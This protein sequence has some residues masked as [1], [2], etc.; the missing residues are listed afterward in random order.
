[1]FGLL[2]DSTNVLPTWQSSRLPF[3]PHG[4]RGASNCNQRF[5]AIFLLQGV[6]QT[7]CLCL[8]LFPITACQLYSPLRLS[9]YQG[10]GPKPY[11]LVYTSIVIPVFVP[12]T[13]YSKDTFNRP[14]TNH[15]SES[16]TETS[17]NFDAHAH[18]GS[19]NTHT[20]TI[21]G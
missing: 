13:Q 1:M 19:Y 11:D 17:V 20:S 9:S 16:L 5:P 21:D 4:K 12:T 14:T 3:L 2:N 7:M 10:T 15:G 18:Q 6:S 8:F